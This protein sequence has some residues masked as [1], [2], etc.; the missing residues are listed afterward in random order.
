MDFGKIL[1]NYGE[2]SRLL[3]NLN[4]APISVA[5]L[6]DAAQAQF[7]HELSGKKRALI[8]SYSDLEARALYA[9]LSFFNKDVLYFPAKEYLFY[10]VDARER[11]EEHLRLSVLDRFQKSESVTV[12]TSVEALLCYT[13]PPERFADVS[14]SFCVGDEVDL[15]RIERKLLSMGYKRVDMVE[16][17]GQFSLRGGIMDIFSPNCENPVRVEFFDVEVDSIRE[18]D[19]LS[20]RSLENIENFHVIPCTE[21][22]VT[23]ADK[24][25]LKK[26]I[27]A[28]I[29]RYQRKK[30]D[31]SELIN[32][33]E[34]DLEMLTEAGEVGA[35]DK[36]ITAV[37]EGVPTIADYLKADDFVFLIEP[38][39]VAE[40]VKTI[41]WEEGERVASLAE[42]GVLAENKYGFFADYKN[43]RDNFAKSKLISINPLSHSSID[44]QYG[45]IFNFQTRTTVN[46]HGKLEYLF[47]DLERWCKENYTVVIL[48]A[49]STKGENLAGEIREKGIDCTFKKDA[50]EFD[51][52]KVTIIDGELKK[53]FEYPELKFVLISDREIF[54]VKKSRKTR[55]DKNT[56]R[57]KAYTDINPGDYVVHQSHGIGQYMGIH[58]MTVAGITKDY[59]KIQ[60][61]GT[62]C[63]Y[64]PVEQMD[65]LYKY[66]GST[67]K[68]VK[69]NSLSG[70]EW[71]KTKQK[72]RSAT[73]EMA[74][75]LVE[76]YAARQNMKGYAFGEDTPWQREF[77]DTFIYT[78]TEDQLRSIEEVKH[79]MERPRPMDRLLCGDVGYGK[80]EVAIRAAFKAVCDS[81]QVAYLCPTTILAMQHFETFLKR[82]EDFPIKVE[83]L[84]RFRTK[85]QQTEI[86][87][88]L[89]NGEIDILIGTHRII[90]KDVEFH[91][92][93]LLIIDEEQ[94]FGVS[95]KER[96]KELKKDIDVLSM[97]AT[98]IPRTLHMS[99]I[100]V[101][102]MSILEEPPENR[103][104][105]R[106][107]VMEH[108]D[109]VIIDAIKRELA[110]GGQ[111][112]YLY[113]RV[114]GINRIAENIK[115]AIPDAN[116]LVGHGKMSED[117]LEDIMYDMADGR[118]DVLVCTTIIET[119]LDIPNANTII[120]ENADRMGLAQLYQLRGRVGR[121]NRNA[122]AYLTYRRDGIIS[123]VAQ[124]RLK[125]IS[126]FT[127]FGSGFK[128]AMRDLEIRGAG[129]IL[130]SQQH[131]HMDAV[132]YDMYCKILKASIDK[133]QGKEETVRE[134]TLIDVDID[135]YIPEKY[136]ANPNQRIDMYKRIAQIDS[137]TEYNEV[138][139]ELIDRFGEPPKSVINLTEIALIKYEATELGLSEI[140]AKGDI[141][142]LVFE[143]Q[144][145]EPDSVIALVAKYPKEISLSPRSE[146]PTLIYRPK[147]KKVLSNIKF[148]LHEIFSLK[149]TGD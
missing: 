50:V 57:L 59:L 81:K 123:E 65:L 16:G 63:L 122:Y 132:G 82:M 33:L 34:N 25:K 8:V 18:F 143:G 100:N 42:S 144:Y 32:T 98:P 116:V 54:N 91:D 138:I 9:D 83:M 12:V 10:N 104:P 148:I 73:D 127:E 133:I 101:R 47:E 128:I 56:Q 13:V 52:G 68:K 26:H 113:N 51:E 111:V 17:R 87:K 112:F 137:E 58:K 30:T 49:S 94:R 78:E 70:S 125:A 141:I 4:K 20:Q 31:C 126:E 45:A 106:T 40:K 60:Y 88:R 36:Y 67:D 149:N 142:R 5:G 46:F 21:A 145:F 80:T 61:N 43:I 23:D 96:L 131:G 62:D 136:I 134:A 19:V 72:V 11:R 74:K 24:E 69:V 139:D 129:N 71:N 84:S 86:L 3:A 1:E 2:Y 6:V 124:K 108:D 79:D 93:G 55:R 107:L 103:Y 147:D 135:A 89:K 118:C 39:R 114:S 120:I 14:F 22:I 15:E 37:Y 75:Q 35:I 29:K 130:G 28:E 48:T 105:V 7:I 44:Y 97:T 102:D 76:L 110:R 27:G 66:I 95:D 121:T 90:Q 99:M 140:S 92:L 117:E 41:E 53:G 77:E 115:R 119:G 64:V 109:T 146:K 85:K 38:K